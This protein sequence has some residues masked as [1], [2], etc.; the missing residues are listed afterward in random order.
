MGRHQR[1]VMDIIRMQYWTDTNVQLL[2]WNWKPEAEEQAKEAFDLA[3]ELGIP[4]YD[5]GKCGALVFARLA[6]KS[7]RSSKQPNCT[8]RVNPSARLA[9]S[10]KSTLTSR[11]LSKSLR[12]SISRAKSVR[13]SLMCYSRLFGTL[14]PVSV[15][16]RQT[17]IKSMHLFT[18]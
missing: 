13:S 2:V 15:Y 18:L 5:T 10:A 1:S 7:N 6:I 8:E 3:F 9:V 12:Q 11:S 17:S 4:F 16:K 14:W